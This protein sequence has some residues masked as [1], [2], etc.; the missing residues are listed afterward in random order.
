[1]KYNA[2]SNMKV[3]CDKSTALQGFL[4]RME[5]RRLKNGFLWVKKYH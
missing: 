3:G 5:L 1:M 2:T 4:T